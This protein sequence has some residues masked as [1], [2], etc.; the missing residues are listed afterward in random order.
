V[1]IE[2]EHESLDYRLAL[3]DTAERRK[4]LK[5]NSLIMSIESLEADHHYFLWIIGGATRQR[6]T[7]YT[8]A[9]LSSQII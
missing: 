8:P 6:R 1:T 9:Q 7:R 2:A 5:D 3:E 4:G